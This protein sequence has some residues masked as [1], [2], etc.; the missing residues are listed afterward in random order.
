MADPRPWEDNDD[1]KEYANVPSVWPH[2][3]TTC[4]ACQT[5]G[6]W[7]W[8]ARFGQRTPDGRQDHSRTQWRRASREAFQRSY[9]NRFRAVIEHRR[10]VNRA[11]REAPATAKLVEVEASKFL[12]RAF[13][14][15]RRQRIVPR[16]RRAGRWDR[17][18]GP[19]PPYYACWEIARSDISAPLVEALRAGYPDRFGV[20]VKFPFKDPEQY[21]TAVLRAAIAKNVVERD[22]L[23]VRS[24]ITQAVIHELH[25]VASAQGQRFACLW[26]VSDVDLA[27][28][29]DAEIGPTRLVDKGRGSPELVVSPLMPE[30]LWS[31]DHGYPMPGAEH[32]GLIYGEGVGTGHHWDVTQALNNHIG[33]TL[34]ALRLGLAT[35]S[36]PH[37]VWTGE[38]SW[39]HVEIPMANPQPGDVLGSHWRRVAAVDPAQLD[40]LRALASMLDRLE[41]SGAKTVPGV[42]VAVW[43]HSRSFRT[44]TWQDTVLDL[45]TALEACLGPTSKEEIGLTLR[46]RAAHLLA[47]DDSEQAEAIY[48]DVEDLYGLRSDVVHGNTRLRRTLAEL[49]DAR[50]LDQV[51]ETDRL[52]VLL[53]RWRE[54]VRRAI[55]A[56]L[57]LADPNVGDPLWPLTGNETKVDRIL[58]R[59]DQRDAWRERIAAGAAAYGL[60]LLADPAPPLI[61]YLHRS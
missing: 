59:R 29:A 42:I 13:A 41:N 4:S 61:D 28:V 47:H 19:W 10:L 54:I 16:Q 2:D 18:D 1:P 51:L 39:V 27:A 36:R 20:P 57:L 49:W 5:L 55:T 15:A 53:D 25:R 45:A 11:R 23:A 35:T 32:Q 60:P 34:A 30:A 48:T 56:R 8:F 38:P 7:E 21:V 14:E 58:V 52:H 3:E 17:F 37:M 9:P 33:R 46:T 12:A 44:S 50:G 31:S 24:P 40:G 6:M 22:R 43:R 26:V